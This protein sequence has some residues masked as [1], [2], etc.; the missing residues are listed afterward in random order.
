[1]N[2]F[3]SHQFS[4]IEKNNELPKLSKIFS[5][6]LAG[7][8]IILLIPSLGYTIYHLF[9]FKMF[10]GLSFILINL[11]LLHS[12]FSFWSYRWN[13]ILQKQIDFLKNHLDKIISLQQKILASSNE[14]DIQTIE[15]L[16]SLL[17]I[18]SLNV[19]QETQIIHEILN[20]EEKYIF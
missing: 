18:T 6:S 20:L 11:C 15:H 13:Q 8:F 17:K 5:G 4:L 1:M 19:K 14:R 7:L 10:I 2:Q 12:L 3:F 9:H 16:I